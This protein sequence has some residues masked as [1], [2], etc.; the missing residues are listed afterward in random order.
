MSKRAY[1]RINLWLRSFT[2]RTGKTPSVLMGQVNE[3][4]RDH[5]GSSWLRWAYDIDVRIMD[6][7]AMHVFMPGK[8]FCDWLV[9][10][11]GELTHEYSIAIREFMGEMVGCLHFP[12]SSGLV[13][14]GFG[15]PCACMNNDGEMPDYSLLLF[16]FSKG[17]TEFDKFMG[18]TIVSLTPDETIESEALTWY[19]KLVVGLGMYIS[20]FPEQLR[21]GVPEDLKHAPRYRGKNTKT[22]GVSEKIVTRDGPTPHY[23]TGHFRLLSSERYTKKRG[24]IVFVHGCFVKGQAETVLAIEGD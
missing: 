14:T 11:V 18:H 21:S 17:H 1:T 4:I 6:G 16:S 19:A 23:R 9:G 24:Q 15:I 8:M 13:S 12:C 10:C 20:C 5:E 22:V 2:K 7:E 3:Y